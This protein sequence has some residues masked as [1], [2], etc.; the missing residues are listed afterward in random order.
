MM[1]KALTLSLVIAAVIQPLTAKEAG[2]VAQSALLI[3]VTELKEKVST[4][5]H[6]SIATCFTPLVA[7]SREQNHR[8]HMEDRH[9]ID[10]TRSLFG[11]FDGHGGHEAVDHVEQQFGAHFDANKGNLLATVEAINLEL[12]AKSILNDGT[13]A[14]V[15]CL[16]GAHVKVA[17]T[18][19]SRAI[20]IRNKVAVQSTVDHK[21][22]SEEEGAR[23]RKAGGFVFHYGVPRVGGIAISRTLGD[24]GIK[25][26]P[27]GLGLIATPDIYEWDV[28]AGDLLV[29]AS[30]G[31]W[32]VLS[33]EEVAQEVSLALG[34]Q[35]INVTTLKRATDQLLARAKA[36]QSG[37]NLTAMAIHLSA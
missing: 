30:D 21:P 31:I 8:D 32:D 28:Q 7:V 25:M 17:N 33:N 19:D 4:Q 6:A 37:D 36:K 22:G 9:I 1:Y 35:V 23:I 18:G 16:E 11:V 14:V 26:S 27:E 34:Q 5:L 10:S 20:L 29:L 12:H 24:W 2:Q 15:A 13:T 3:K